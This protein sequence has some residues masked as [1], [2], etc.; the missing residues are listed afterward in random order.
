MSFFV[1]STSY[2]IPMTGEA[3]RLYLPW[4]IGLLVFLLS[5]VVVYT[6]SVGGALHRWQVGL[7]NKLTIEVVELP[8]VADT[9]Q[10]TTATK[11]LQ[12]LQDMPDV[13]SA[14]LVDSSKLLALLKPWVGQVGLLEDMKL[15]SLIDVEVK[16]TPDMD[17]DVL[18]K[19]LQE[20]SPG[21]R[22]EPHTRLQ[23]TLFTFGQALKTISYVIMA[24]I[25][26]VILIVMT[27][28]TKSS[29]L[30]HRAIIDVLRLIGANN[31]YIARQFQ[32]QAFFAAFK[33]GIIGIVL[34][35]PVIYSLS[36]LTGYLGIPEVLKGVIGPHVFVILAFIPFVISF[37]S[38]VISRIAVFRTLVRME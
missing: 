11:V 36:W 28:I 37:L 35:I 18:T 5:L 17:L 2:D 8:V 3:G 30:A 25:V 33:G 26:C 15:P 22:V 16:Q 24:M 19:T 27:L 20:I 10:P 32:R 31:K 21:I 9:N 7:S 12:A 29:L 1:K 23:G 34:A 38:M 14:E 4:I 13:I 6:A